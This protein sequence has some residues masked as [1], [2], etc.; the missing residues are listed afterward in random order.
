MII[1]TRRRIRRRCRRCFAAARGA[2]SDD[3]DIAG[4]LDKLPPR[5]VGFFELKFSPLPAVFWRVALR[6]RRSRRTGIT[7]DRE[8]SLTG[9][10]GLAWVAF[11]RA[12]VFAVEP[13]AAVFA[14]SPRISGITLDRAPIF[15][16]DAV[17]AVFAVNPHAVGSVFAGIPVFAREA[18]KLFPRHDRANEIR[19]RERRQFFDAFRDFTLDQRLQVFHLGRVSIAVRFDPG[20]NVKPPR[21]PDPPH[22]QRVRQ[23]F[24][25]PPQRRLE[26]PQRRLDLCLSRDRRPPKR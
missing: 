5:S 7:L 9:L 19:G 10:P 8:T 15:P 11:D 17:S 16:I 6:P 3:R 20:N 23:S 1:G 14:G 12:A 4:E 25:R 21:R 13:V 22:H 18:A 2:V 26:R 24:H